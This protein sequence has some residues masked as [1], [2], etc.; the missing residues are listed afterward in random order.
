MLKKWYAKLLVL[1]AVVCAVAA[2]HPAAQAEAIP[3]ETAQTQAESIPEEIEKEQTESD[4]TIIASGTCGNNL[5][6]SLDSAGTL[7]ISGSGAMWDYYGGLVAPWRNNLYRNTIKLLTLPDGL[8]SIGMD[9]FYNCT[10]LT[11]VTFPA[12][13][14]SI[15]SFAFKGCSKLT[16]VT[17]PDGLTS[18]G[19][20]AFCGCAELTSVTFPEGL[21]SIHWG[22]F[23]RCGL[24]GDLAFPTSL[25]SIGGCAFYKCSGFKGCTLELPEG[26]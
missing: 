11:S 14:T 3:E 26:L 20:Q 2:A 18:I 24:T 25:T 23:Y 13:L 5:T 12:S 10:N 1:L 4:V 16:G 8:T 21:T 6:W 7:S 22:A 19:E 15:G 9:A 17:F